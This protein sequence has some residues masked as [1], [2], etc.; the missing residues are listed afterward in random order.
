MVKAHRSSLAGWV[1]ALQTRVGTLQTSEAHVLGGSG[2]LVLG[3][4][5]TWAFPEGIPAHLA[6]LLLPLVRAWCLSEFSCRPKLLSANPCQPL[7]PLSSLRQ[8]GPP[9]A[10]HLWP[11]SMGEGALSALVCLM[12]WGDALLLMCSLCYILGPVI[13]AE[14]GDTILVT[15]FNKASW[16]FSIQPHGVFYGKASEGTWYH[17]GW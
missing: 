7:L 13:K 8:P 16:P 1:V 2:G 5:E 4:G 10:S 15:F 6:V 11:C 9:A 3:G 17:D 14:V 12:V